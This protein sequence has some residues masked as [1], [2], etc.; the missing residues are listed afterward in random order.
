[1][2]SWTEAVRVN[3]RPVWTR[4]PET[5]RPSAIIRH[6]RTSPPEIGLLVPIPCLL[7][8]VPHVDF[9]ILLALPAPLFS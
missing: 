6:S 8:S 3:A 1:M 4:R 9:L 5:C 2:R 7:C